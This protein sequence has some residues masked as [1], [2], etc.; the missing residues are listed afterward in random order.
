MD[1]LNFLKAT[2]AEIEKAI[3][4]YLP[5]KENPQKL[6][7]E[8]MRY[9]VL[10]GGKR[11]RGVLSVACCLLAGGKKEE[12]MPFAAAVE[13]VHAYSL[14][15]DDLPSMDNDSMRRG[16]P[17]NHLVYGEA[18]AILAGDGLLGMAFETVLE[19]LD[20][21]NT[22]KGSKA[23]KV[24]AK[25][26]G[27]SGMLGGQVVDMQSENKK[28]DYDTLVYLQNHKTGALIEAACLMGAIMGEANTDLIEKL[29]EY[30]AKI[31]L[32]FQIQDDILDVIG[33]EKVL[34]K[35]IG[36]DTE[37]RKS[38][39]VTECG[40]EKAKELVQ[41]LSSEAATIVEGI[42]EYGDFLA[43]LAKYLAGREN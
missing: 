2:A 26:L 36:S 10:G 22:K 43:W 17:T 21:T 12:V 39:F 7:Y 18:T 35:P 9:S 41:K 4:E 29:K 28:I 24:L 5:V 42:N 34:G 37:S 23:L 25:N 19:R 16:K 20:E 1:N 30:A 3:D 8:A 31:G 33:D 11:L 38:T 14:V 27:P 13:M 32:A 15:H 40:I 6:I